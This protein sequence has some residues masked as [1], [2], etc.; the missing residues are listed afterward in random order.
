MATTLASN[1]ALQSM[2]NAYNSGTATLTNLNVTGDLTVNGVSTL[3]LHKIRGD[4][5]GIPGRADISIGADKWTRLYEYGGST[6]AGEPHVGGFAAKNLWCRDT[7]GQ[8]FA[9][10]IHAGN[11][12]AS[13]ISTL[14][15]LKVQG[16]SIGLP[17][18]ADIVFGP[19]DNWIRALTHGSTDTGAYAPG[20]GFASND[21]WFNGTLHGGRV[22]YAGGQ[23]LTPE[24]WGNG[25][26]NN[27]NTVTAALRVAK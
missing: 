27:A 11:L 12:N 23:C 14:G 24:A 7:G 6:Y 2:A 9:E 21:M 18:K 19:N 15:N 5:I 13:G 8:L 3:G 10:T 25:Y 20:G 17:G 4:R 22:C 1:E 16:N 26:R